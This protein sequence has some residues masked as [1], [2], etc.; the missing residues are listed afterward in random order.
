MQ[1]QVFVDFVD[2]DLVDVCMIMLFN[3]VWYQG[4]I[5]IVV[6]WFKEKFYC[7]LFMFV[8]VDDEGWWVKGL[9]WLIVGF[10]L[11]DVFDFVLKCELD[12]IVVFGGYV[13]VV[14]FM[15]DIDNVLCF[16]AV[17]EVVVCEWLFDDVFVC[18]IEIDGEF[19]DVYFM[20]QFV[21][22]FDE[23]VWG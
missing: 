4:V 14:G 19:E 7:L 1:Q 6:G 11:C 12:L 17:F 22:L 21:G 5:G 13:M 3:F 10:Y 20:L 16:V 18:V 9:G 8:Y 23:V 15:F 2:V